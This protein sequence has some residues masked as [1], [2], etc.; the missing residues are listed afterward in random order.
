MA[1][2][3][4]RGHRCLSHQRL[5]DRQRNRRP[6]RAPYN[7]PSYKGYPVKGMVCALRYEGI[8]TH[9]ATTRDHI[10]PLSKGGTNHPS[11]LQ[12]ACRECNSHKHDQLDS[13]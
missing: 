4:P 10:I 3:G 12:P 2:G 8:C 9:W 1:L 6:Q 11:N 5:H 7:D 13:D